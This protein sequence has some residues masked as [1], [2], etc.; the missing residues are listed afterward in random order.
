M[1]VWR[2]K[3]CSVQL[4]FWMTVKSSPAMEQINCDTARLWGSPGAGDSGARSLSHWI[5]LLCSMVC[6]E[7]CCSPFLPVCPSLLWQDILV[8]QFNQ[9]KAACSLVERGNVLPEPEGVW[10]MSTEIPAPGTYWYVMQMRTSDLC[11]L[12]GPKVLSWLVRIKPFWLVTA[13]WLQLDGG[14]PQS[15]RSK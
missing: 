15:Y 2:R 10:L 14:E 12:I 5:A 1:V 4:W 6:F 8:F 11:S 7:L 3:L 9:G 13:A